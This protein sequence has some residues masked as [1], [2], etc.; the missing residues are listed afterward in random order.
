MTDQALALTELTFIE[1]GGGGISIKV[2]IPVM[3]FNFERCSERTG[4]LILNVHLNDL[5]ILLKYR[6]WFSK[7]GAEA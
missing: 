1:G 6:F 5:G 3:P 2:W 4:L 7:P